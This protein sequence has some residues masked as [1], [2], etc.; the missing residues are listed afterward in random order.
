MADQ[1]YFS[2]E[3]VAEFLTNF[4]QNELDGLATAE[5]YSQQLA[6]YLVQNELANAK[7]LWKRIPEDVKTATEELQKIWTVG[8]KMWLKDYT[9]VYTALRQEWS[10]I[11]KPLMLVLEGKIRDHLFELVQ[12]AYTSIHLD[13]FSLF[14]GMTADSA[15]EV[16]RNHNWQYDDATKMLTPVKRDTGARKSS[17]ITIKSDKQLG[18]LTDYVSFLELIEH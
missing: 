4:E 6:I 2:P 7:F 1:K 5:T 3:I 11:V 10:E 14:L 8:C 17:D 9:G 16:A 18:I 12:K 15:L 13:K